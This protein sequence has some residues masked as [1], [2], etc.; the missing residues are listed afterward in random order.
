MKQWLQGSIAGAVGGSFRTIG[1]PMGLG[2]GAECGCGCGCGCVAGGGGGRCVRPE[3][4]VR[5]VWGLL[6]VSETSAAPESVPQNRLSGCVLCAA[7]SC[8]TGGNLRSPSSPCV[9]LRNG[10]MSAEMWCVHWS[11]SHWCGT[12]SY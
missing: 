3:P 2:L 4:I 8:A 12:V 9:M 10:V 1:A 5:C 7:P 6:R 11:R